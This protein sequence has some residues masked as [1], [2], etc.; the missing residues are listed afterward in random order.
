[1]A[2]F[3]LQQLPEYTD[4]P[5]V[6]TRDVDTLK[7]CEII[8]DV[9]GVYDPEHLRFDHH[10]R[11]FKDCFSEHHKIRL[12]SAGLI[13]KHF[14]KRVIPEILK[15]HAP[16]I[17][18]SKE[19]L[20]VI[21]LKVYK[22]L[23]ISVDGNDNGIYPYQGVKPDS[24]IH[25]FKVSTDLPSRVGRLNPRWNQPDVTPAVRDQQF[26]KAVEI[27]GEELTSILLQQ[28]LSW[29]PVQGLVSEAIANRFKHHASGQIVVLETYCPWL[30]TFLEVEEDLQL[31]GAKPL[32]FVLFPDSGGSWRVQAI[33]VDENH[34][35]T[36]RKSLP[37]AW[38]GVRDDKLAEQI[39]IPGAI[40][41]H[42]NGF[43][44]GAKTFEG[45]LE[46]ANQALVLD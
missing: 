33:P 37:Q 15:K 22:D 6:R 17:N 34:R 38:R 5:I 12:S 1:M 43:I 23:I 20:D 2:C 28:V 9:G 10:Q 25:N 39:G 41:V 21:Y 4:A 11:E 19:Q 26:L 31:T 16:E 14:G 8:V 27:T 29:L 46:M 32:L 35:F 3:M 24:I 36:N 45:A 44:G 40:F 18:L 13:Y 7:A 30:D 42:A